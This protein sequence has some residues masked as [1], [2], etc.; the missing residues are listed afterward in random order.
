[1]TENKIS[2]T[3]TGEEALSDLKTHFPNDWGNYIQTGKDTINSMMRIFKLPAV[4]AVEKARKTVVCFKD[5]TIITAAL[6]VMVKQEYISGELNKVENEIKQIT[7]QSFALEKSQNFNT[8]ESGELR[9]Y[10]TRKLDELQ[11]KHNELINEFPVVQPITVKSGE[12]SIN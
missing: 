4:Q 11:R 9:Q 6:Y 3:I 7:D 2:I 12:F 8:K 5:P 10:Y 1:M